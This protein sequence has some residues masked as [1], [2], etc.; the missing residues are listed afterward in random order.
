VGERQGRRRQPVAVINPDYLP[1]AF[2]VSRARFF[3]TY[4]EVLTYM[5]TDRFDPAGEVVLKGRP[6]AALPG[7]SPGGAGRAEITDFG[8]HEISI[9]VDAEM[10]CYL[11]TSEVHYP[12]WRAYVDGLEAE[13]LRADYAFRAV[14]L[15]PGT[16]V[17]RMTYV[18]TFFR[19]GL[20]FSMAGAALVGVLIKSRRGLP[21]IPERRYLP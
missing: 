17:V 18:P 2:L 16:H 3:E 8:P 4:E 13:M 20:L 12:G 11:V 14:K 21:A 1:R 7:R 9:S 6:E 5:G 19:I 10:E 15:S